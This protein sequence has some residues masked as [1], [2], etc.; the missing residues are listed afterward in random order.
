MPHLQPLPRAWIMTDERM[1]AAFPALLARAPHGVGVVFRHYWLAPAERRA[2]LAHTLRIARRRRQCVLVAGGGPWLRGVAG[3]HNGPPGGHGLV[4]R[5]VHSRAEA[6]AAKR[7]GADLVFISPVFATRS[8]PGAAPRGPLRS[9]AMVRGLGIPAI[10]LGGVSAR[11]MRRL[12]RLG[13]YGWA[14]IDAWLCGRAMTRPGIAIRG[15]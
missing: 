9:A 11:D 8:H 13:F 7:K 1:G 3:T 14:G 2:L 12:G 10:A 6:V 5:A 4:S 15:C